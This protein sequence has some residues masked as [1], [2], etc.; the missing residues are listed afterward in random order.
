MRR[1]GVQ[2]Q[3][4]PEVV[5]HRAGLDQ[6]QDREAD[7]LVEHL[8][9]GRVVGAR[10]AAADV[11]LVRPVAGEPDEPAAGEDRPGDHP[12]RQVVATGLP[13][14]VEEIDVA[15]LH[16]V[17]EIAQDRAHPEPAA[18]GMDRDAVGLAHDLAVRPGDEAGEIVRLAEDRAAGGADHHPAHLVRD[19]VEAVLG[20]R[21]NDGVEVRLGHGRASRGASWSARA[22]HPRLVS[23]SAVDEE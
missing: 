9:G 18:P 19:V 14:V 2:H 11:G 6:A 16:R 20:Q 22:D 17:A 3:E 12:V 7:A 13:R 10:R 21:Q 23:W 15:F 8:G 1:A 4:L 5:A